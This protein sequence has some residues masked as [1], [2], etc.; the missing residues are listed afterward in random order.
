MKYFGIVALMIVLTCAFFAPK[1]FNI[2]NEAEAV[3][4]IRTEWIA[5][6]F[7]TNT[8]ALV[9]L[10]KLSQNQAEKAKIISSRYRG[11][12]VFYPSR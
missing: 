8:D 6:T 9:F 7:R 12:T 2:I 3:E 4:V 1:P 5:V 11:I 10:N